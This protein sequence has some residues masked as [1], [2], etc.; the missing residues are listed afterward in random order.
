MGGP[1]DA[2]TTKHLCAPNHCSR[3]HINDVGIGPFGVVGHK[4]C[5]TSQR[6]RRGVAATATADAQ[7]CRPCN[8]FGVRHTA[9]REA[10]RLHTQQESQFHS[11]LRTA[12]RVLSSCMHPRVLTDI[13]RSVLRENLREE[14]LEFH[15]VVA[16]KRRVRRHRARRKLARRVAP[17]T[18]GSQWALRSNEQRTNFACH[19]YSGFDRLRTEYYVERHFYYLSKVRTF[20]YVV[21]NYCCFGHLTT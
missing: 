14:I 13:C 15:A 19:R 21:F 3:R 2:S 12:D 11:S 4:W 7:R 17:G 9:L 10:H 20:P 16:G 6:T 1:K 18:C 8:L 5:S